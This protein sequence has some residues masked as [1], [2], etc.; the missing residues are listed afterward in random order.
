MFYMARSNELILTIPSE[1]GTAVIFI[2]CLIEEA[3]R[4][5]QSA[6]GHKASKW[7][8]SVTDP[9]IQ[10]MDLCP[11]LKIRLVSSTY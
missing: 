6:Y 7:W 2:L 5:T 9:D 10:D 3:Q 1:V 11:S 8:G 4:I